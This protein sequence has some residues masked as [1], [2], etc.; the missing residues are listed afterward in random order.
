F[1]NLAAFRQTNLKRL[2]AYSTIA[3]AGYMVMGLATLSLDGA[4]AVLVYLVAYLLMNLGAFAVVAFIRN[5][6]GS[7]ELADYRGLVR[8]SPSRSPPASTPWS[9]RW[10][11]WSACSPG[12]RWRRPARRA[13]RLPKFSPAPTPGGRSDERHARPGSAAPHRGARGTFADAVH[14]RRLPVDDGDPQRGAR[15]A[16]GHDRGGARRAGGADALPLPPQG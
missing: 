2:L 16:P 7:E 10:S 15:P 5:Q 8:R 11:S 9:C 4:K 1:G 3:H 14:A 6:T 13:F 12:R